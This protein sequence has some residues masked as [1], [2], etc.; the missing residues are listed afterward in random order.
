MNN[1]ETFIEKKGIIEE[2]FPGATFKVKL[3]NGFTIQAVIA[4]KLRKNTKV[5]PGDEVIVRISSYD[6]NRGLIIKRTT[7]TPIINVV[8]KRKK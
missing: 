6:Y 5:I 3:E 2:S 8:H 4:G 7:V 1:E